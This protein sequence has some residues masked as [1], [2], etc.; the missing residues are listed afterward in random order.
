MQNR[1]TIESRRSGITTAAVAP[2]VIF[3]A[4][5]VL[6]SLVPAAAAGP[7]A[8][9]LSV[10]LSRPG[11]PVKVIAVA[12]WSGIHVEGY[13]GADVR[14]WS[15]GDED[16]GDQRKDGLRRIP[17]VSFGVTAEE[18]N[19]QVH[20]QVDGMASG[21]LML[22]VPRRASLSLKTVNGGEIEV[23]GV[24]GELELSNTN[25][26]IVARDVEGAVVAHT[27]NGD[28]L[29]E[30]KRIDPASPMSFSTLNGDLDV[31]MPAATKADL[32]IK[33]THGEIY[34]D[35]DVQLKPTAARVHEERVGGRYRVELEKDVR[36]TINGG[37]P[38]LE[39]R[40]FNGDVYLRKGS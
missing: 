18:E 19:N 7:P 9:A 25:G 11:Q 13:D 10:P 12:M 14:V 3:A 17:N 37:G 28:V 1:N 15:E 34:T 21:E 5:L 30:L 20:V 26:E 23:R 38:V 33:S 6:G 22:W 8:E 27:T 36:G 31:T 39:F 16:E 35:F 32:A 29:V 24:H 2:A 4:M 40:T